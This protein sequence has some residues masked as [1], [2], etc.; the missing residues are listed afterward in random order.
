MLIDELFE[1]N[2]AD[3]PP[4]MR[5]RLNMRDIEKMRPKGAYS[6]QVTPGKAGFQIQYFMNQDAAEAYAQRSGGQVK[7]L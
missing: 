1:M 4:T 5:R 2:L 6:F 7:A 3:V